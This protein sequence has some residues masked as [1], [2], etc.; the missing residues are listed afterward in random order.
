MTRSAVALSH[1][2][3][4][5]AWTLNPLL[6]IYLGFFAIW[7]G[8]SVYQVTTGRSVRLL[9]WMSHHLGLIA[10]VLTVVLFVFGGVR[11]WWLVR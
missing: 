1:L 5:Q 6:P 7:W 2:D 10:A 8:L 9:T 11:I 4:G 3:F